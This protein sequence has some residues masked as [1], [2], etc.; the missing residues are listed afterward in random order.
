MCTHHHHL[1]VVCLTAGAVRSTHMYCTARLALTSVS[2]HYSGQGEKL[3]THLRIVLRLGMRGAVPL[4]VHT[5]AIV[6]QSIIKH[7]DNVTLT[8]QQTP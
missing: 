6:K 7:T 8:L 4:I 1:P 2:G 5:P 3:T